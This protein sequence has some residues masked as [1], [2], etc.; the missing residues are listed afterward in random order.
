[1]LVAA[2]CLSAQVAS[3]PP[4]RLIPPPPPADLGALVAKDVAADVA[5]AR[6]CLLEN[7]VSPERRRAAAAVIA[8][9]RGAGG[10]GMVAAVIDSIVECAGTCGATRDLADLLV[11]MAAEAAKSAQ[12]ALG[13]AVR[14]MMAEKGA[15]SVAA[16]ISAVVASR[17]G[18]SVGSSAMRAAETAVSASDPASASVRAYRV[19]RRNIRPP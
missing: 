12:W 9:A 6:R 3:L 19:Q 17:R 1:M 11:S 14:G 13:R 4:A 2:V 15:P 5:T 10:A 7:G 8:D 16:V 18:V